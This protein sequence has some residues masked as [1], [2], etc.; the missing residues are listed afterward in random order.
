MRRE[1]RRQAGWISASV[2]LLAALLFVPTPAANSAVTLPTD[3]FA[4]CSVNAANNYCIE[5]VSVQP[6]G[7]AAIALQWVATGGAGPTASKS[8]GVVA[9]RD[10][11]R[12][13]RLEP[14]GRSSSTPRRRR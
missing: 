5:S 9:G 1:T 2:S 6:V 13:V 11:H 8:D 4:P 3:P 10:P 12:R 14:Q 7:L